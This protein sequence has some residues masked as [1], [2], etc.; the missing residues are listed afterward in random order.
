MFMYYSF[1]VIL[2]I[3]RYITHFPTPFKATEGNGVDRIKDNGR[4]VME[5]RTVSTEGLPSNNQLPSR[6]KTEP[7]FKPITHTKIFL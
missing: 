3:S 4:G 1:L 2:L 5:G 7:W 6:R